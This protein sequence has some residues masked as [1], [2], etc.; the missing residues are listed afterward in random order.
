MIRRPPRSTLF[1]YTTL[2]RSVGGALLSVLLHA[3]S[4]ETCVSKASGGQ[5]ERRVA[6]QD[7][8]AHSPRRSSSGGSSRTGKVPGVGPHNTSAGPGLNPAHKTKSPAPD[9]NRP[10][11]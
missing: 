8:R 6:R 3:L 4:E 1:P 9:D 7:R 10:L 2:F 11:H 5:P